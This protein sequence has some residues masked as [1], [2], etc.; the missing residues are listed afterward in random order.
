MKKIFLSLSCML[1]LFFV[2]H[3][4]AADLLHVYQDALKNDPTFKAA[5]STKMS[6]AE[7]VPQA[8][9]VLLP[10]INLTETGGLG[11]IQTQSTVLG[12][13]S[14]TARTRSLD[15]DLS[16][17]QSVFNFANWQKL[18]SAKETVKAAQATYNAAAQDLMI[19]TSQAYF[20]VLQAKEVLRYTG[21]EK[22]ALY[23]EYV[24][25]EQSFKVG[26]KTITDVYNARASYDDAIA[27]YVQA[28][29]TLANKR[30]DLRS[31][32]GVLYTE[33][34]PLKV[35]I[36]LVEPTPSNINQWVNVAMQQNWQLISSRFTANAA[37]KDISAAFG[38]HLPT[39]DAS[40]NY[41]ND[42]TR[43]FDAGRTRARG[44]SAELDLTVPLFSGGDVSSTVRQKVADY[45]YAS[46]IQ[47][48]TYRSVLN[49]TR[50][51][52]L[53]VLS[54]ISTVRA[55]KQAI[56]SNRSSLKGM[57]EGYRVGTRTIVDVLNA[58]RALYE[59]QK[60]YAIARYSYIMSGLTLKQSAGTLSA[61][62][63]QDLNTWLQVS[64]AMPDAAVSPAVTS[65]Q[66][67]YARGNYLQ[68]GVYS[69]KT[70]AQNMA[71]DIQQK[72]G[73]RARIETHKTGKGLMY[74]VK[75]G[76]VGGQKQALQISKKLQAK[77]F[78]KPLWVN[79]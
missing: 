77:H 35:K 13:T 17:T 12:Y 41:S 6:T 16:L 59:V 67:T 36:P 47:D 51:S 56:I 30:E 5:L 27:Q 31:I 2:S 58:Q 7:N 46:D 48:Q 19:R 20:D 72:T 21:A 22:K 40:V 52:Y 14:A 4:Y 53:G 60:N 54:G 33:L 64:Q 3:A 63:L 78:P 49:S 57:Q 18:A 73:L 71:R 43:T 76:P 75:I 50:K 61:N 44:P 69:K 28:Q 62:D 79:N 70:N 29:N 37:Q 24:Q 34:A 66:N 38:G 8:I 10:Q 68:V 55:Q 23:Q 39:L 32:T 45:E 9:A 15:L 26:I 74:F 65:K 25:A 1:I 11:K 42:Y